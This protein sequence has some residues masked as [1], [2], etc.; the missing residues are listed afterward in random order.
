MQDDQ[1][2]LLRMGVLDPG[3]LNPT[4]KVEKHF[5]MDEWQPSG[6]GFQRTKFGGDCRAEEK[7]FHS[8]DSGSFSEFEWTEQV[9]EQVRTG[10]P[11]N[12]GC[13][14]YSL[15]T[16]NSGQTPS[17]RMRIH[18][19]PPVRRHITFKEPMVGNPVSDDYGR[20]EGSSRVVDAQGIGETEFCEEHPREGIDDHLEAMQQNS[21]TSSGRIE[22]RNRQPPPQI[23][24]DDI[25]LRGS[26]YWNPEYQEVGHIEPEEP[27]LTEVLYR[28]EEEP[29]DTVWSILTD[30]LWY[31]VDS[32]DK[33]PVSFEF[34]KIEPNHISRI[35]QNKNNKEA[36]NSSRFKNYQGN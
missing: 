36:K 6:G 22:E 26:I 35:V 9:K 21:I 14:D 33:S 29:V 28:E 5:E 32:T 12:F 34:A 27:H 25:R 23:E 10:P 2:F 3:E 4:E 15:S 7:L 1:M 11:E 18:G 8:C 31:T 30:E 13:T 24:K 17:L 16:G 20:P 19:A